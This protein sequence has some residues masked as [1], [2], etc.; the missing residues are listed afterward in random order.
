MPTSPSPYRVTAVTSC[1]AV[2]IATHWPKD[3]WRRLMRL[4]LPIRHVAAAIMKA[5]PEGT[6]EILASV[7]PRSR[8]LAQPADKLKKLAEVLLLEGDT[9]YLRLVS[10]C[11]DPCR[12]DAWPDRACYQSAAAHN[13]PTRGASL[14]AC[15]CS[16]PRPIC[17]TIFCKG[18]PRLDGSRA[19]SSPAAPGSSR[20]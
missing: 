17:R 4:P 8:R 11:P 9:V 18:R 5:I 16:T 10:Q 7:V 3:P 20:R 1:S 15:S 6:A 2:T 13:G 19:R 12:F 14:S